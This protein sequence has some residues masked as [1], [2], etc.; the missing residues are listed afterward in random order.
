M[1]M[2]NKDKDKEYFLSKVFENLHGLDARDCAMKSVMSNMYNYFHGT[3]TNSSFDSIYDSFSING[4]EGDKLTLPIIHLRFN[5]IRAKIKSLVGD[6]IDMGYEIH[7]EAINQEAKTRITEQKAK[8][9][10]LY[11]LRPA[12]EYAAAQTGIEVGVG[13]DIP[14]SHE[15]L[16]EMLENLKENTEIAME[17]CLRVSLANCKWHY[18]R[19][20]LFID[21]VI[22]GECHAKTHIINGEAII[23]RIN[24][25]N[26][27]YPIVVDDNDFLDKTNSF[28]IVYYEALNEVL[29]KYNISEAD[30]KKLES[31]ANKFFNGLSHKGKA[32]LTRYLDE[33]KDIVSVIECYWM[34][35][36]K[37]AGVERSN[38]HG[39]T[40]FSIDYNNNNGKSYKNGEKVK[41]KR[42]GVLRKG[43]LING[44]LLAE[45]GDVENQPRYIYDYARAQK[46]ITSYRPFYIN[47]QSTS[48]VALM[49]QAQDFRDYLLNVLQLEITK[50]GGNVI[51][52]DVSKLPADWGDPQT[53][54]KTMLYYLKSMGVYVYDSS[55]GEIPDS[56]AKAV[57]KFDI[58]IG[59]VISA[60]ISLMQFIDSEMDGMSAINEARM[61]NATG[62]ELASVTAMNLSQSNKVSKYVF[63]GFLEFESILLTKHA[64]HIRTSW[65]IDPDRWRAAVGDNAIDLLLFD[66]D[67]T[68]DDHAIKVKQGVISRSDL[69]NYL[70]A[71]IQHG[72]PIEDALEIEMIAVDD[73][74]LALHKFIKS[75]RIATK[76]AQQMQAQMAQQQQMAMLQANQ[77]KLSGQQAVIDRQGENDREKTKLKGNFDLQ[78][79]ILK[80]KKD[81][82][83]DDYPLYT[84]S[85]P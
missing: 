32:Y 3:Q 85:S 39:D 34:E 80:Q 25:M 82:L 14:E 49:S 61:G 54:I 62:R 9:L 53:A 41:R 43:V 6:L 40:S 23:D 63:N 22:A 78:K 77:D 51:A 42:V 4:G 58:G 74:K 79:T 21:A 27:F 31:S 69:K 75:R 73:I 13:D 44:F 29:R 19:L 67:M 70:L 45:W 81:S 24:P 12:M 38:E 10:A 83:I 60:Y 50:A 57:D 1:A 71:A 64:Q 68:L 76:E 84:E 55:Q 56:N 5:K 66:S 16:K 36:K 20:Q 11:E 47:G 15:E 46:N 17:A 48:E 52:I 65:S 26:M 2:D 7:V 28:C 72:M 18:M 35:S 59:S 33:R 30:F 8:M 37:V